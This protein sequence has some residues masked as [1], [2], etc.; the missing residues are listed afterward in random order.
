MVKVSFPAPEFQL[1][2]VEKDGQ[3]CS[4]YT[5]GGASKADR[6]TVLFFYPLDFTFVCPTEITAFSEANA[7]FEDMCADVYGISTDSVHSHK[8]W[9]N[10]DLGTLNFPLL[11]DI[12]HEVSR[13]YG[14]LLEAEGVAL[15][16][17]FILD[18]EGVLRYQLVH[19]N[20]IGRNVDEVLRVL[21]A[22]QSGGLCPVNWNKGDANLNG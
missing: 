4:E 22:L 11:A 8:A 3:T 10:S 14:I 21:A 12:T 2:G 5:I 7:Q 13:Q 18:P 6:W 19:D 15:R 17:V 16:G 9:I 20:N 1:E